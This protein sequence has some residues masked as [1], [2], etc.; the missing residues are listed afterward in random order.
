MN[1]PQAEYMILGSP[2]AT[3]GIRRGTIRL[4]TGT[5]KLAS[6][7]ALRKTG[8]PYLVFGVIGSSGKQ[9]HL[10]P[11]S[12]WNAAAGGSIEPF[13]SRTVEGTK[14]SNEILNPSR[15]TLYGP[16]GARMILVKNKDCHSRRLHTHNLPLAKQKNA[17]RTGA[18]GI[19][20]LSRLDGHESGA[21]RSSPS[22]CQLC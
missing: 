6:T 14:F 3:R 18:H 22:C 1:S 20:V 21:R 11:M 16:E 4:Q 9:W 10:L 2:S 8:V 7:K 13:L 15:S 12:F 5:I 19:P 17:L